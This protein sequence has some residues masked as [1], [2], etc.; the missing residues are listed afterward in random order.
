M[1]DKVTLSASVL[2][3]ILLKNTIKKMGEILYFDSK[4]NLNDK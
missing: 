2:K 3:I 1:I 4:I